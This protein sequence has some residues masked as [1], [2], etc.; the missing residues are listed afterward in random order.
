M[1]LHQVNNCLRMDLSELKKSNSTVFTIDSET[2]D[3][4]LKEDCC[5]G[6]DE[7]GRGP[8]LGIILLILCCL[9]TMQYLLILYPLDP[10]W[11]SLTDLFNLVGLMKN[12]VLSYGICSGNFSFRTLFQKIKES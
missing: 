10:K 2:P 8:V 11:S 5:V 3:V 9:L 4:A 1:I 7:A 6:I 12:L